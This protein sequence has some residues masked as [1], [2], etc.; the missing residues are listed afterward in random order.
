[1]RKK[2]LISILLIV[3]SIVV[4]DAGEVVKLDFDNYPDG[5]A[6]DG[7]GGWRLHMP[8]IDKKVSSYTV[9]KGQL[10]IVCNTAKKLRGGYIEIDI[11]LIRKGYLEYDLNINHDEKGIGLFIDF[12]NISLFWH[13]Y[14]Q[15]WRRYFPKPTAKRMKYYDI[16]PV[17]HRRLGKVD[18][19]CWSHYKIYFD[20]DN[21]VVEYYKDDMENPVFIDGAAAVF[22]R[23]EYLGGKLRIGSWGVTKAPMTFLIDNIT[24]STV[25]S[26]N[27]D[28]QTKRDR[29]IIFNGIA[30]NSYNISENLIK[31]GISK[32]NISNFYI[33]NPKPAL[34]PENKFFI[35]KLPGSLAMK[36]AQ[37]LIFVDCPFGPNEVIPDFALKSA[38]E[39]VKQG[40]KLVIFGGLFALGK[41]EYQNSC[42]NDYLPVLLK[43]SWQVKKLKTALIIKPA[44]KSMQQLDWQE[45]PSV[46]YIH[47]LKP[48]DT[49]ETV[50][51]AGKYPLL[52]KQKL[53]KGEIIVFLGTTCGELL[54]NDSN[55]LFWEWQ[56]WNKLIDLIII[57]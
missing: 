56:D 38:I 47:A 17:G 27:A 6:I 26:Q 16:E 51:K 18:K 31:S 45:N 7:K 29:Y 4:L 13:D 9:K 15:D 39:N 46:V 50:L 22:G 28:I 55:K 12:Y 1:M 11:P 57:N 52:V 3:M 24:L 35:N 40:M 48:K 44:V 37:A 8:G 33:E 49:A 5:T 2:L 23:Q 21:D 30:H 14:C 32:K 10:E 34:M 42:L 53:G 19:K 41:G 54:Q 43:D 20:T 36:K 25:D